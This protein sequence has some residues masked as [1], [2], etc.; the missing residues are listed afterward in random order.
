MIR[1]KTE[2]GLV[3]KT[4]IK[5]EPEKN[6][7]YKCSHETT[8]SPTVQVTDEAA[9]THEKKTLIDKIVSLQ[10]ENQKNTL[11]LKNQATEHKAFVLEKQ[12]IEKQLSEKVQLLSTEIIKL[13]SKL[14]QI[15]MEH[16]SL[17]SE[18]GKA[19]ADLKLKIQSLPAQNNQLKTGILQKKTM[20]ENVFEVDKLI[21][22]KK[23]IDGFYFL[24]RWK[25]FN[26]N[27]DTWEHERN[28]MCPK[29][30]NDYKKK[31]NI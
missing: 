16:S 12:T 28:L 1:I 24:V 2:R 21:D 8:K 27:D 11:N 26:S 15:K 4:Q 5:V 25:N 6:T 13:Q 3:A 17:K 18:H 7:K 10:T 29:I 22:H 14:E 20:T 9:W 23:R 31:M 19:V 30:L